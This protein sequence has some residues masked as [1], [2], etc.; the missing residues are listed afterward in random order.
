MD[1]GITTAPD[2]ELFEALPIVN[3]LMERVSRLRRSYRA[4]FEFFVGTIGTRQS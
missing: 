1:T 3:R 2:I 4:T